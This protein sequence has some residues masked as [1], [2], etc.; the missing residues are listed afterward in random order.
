VKSAGYDPDR[1]WDK[2]EALFAEAKKDMARIQAEDRGAIFDEN[3]EMVG[4][5]D[6]G[7]QVGDPMDL[8]L[9]PID[10]VEEE[11]VEGE[12]GEDEQA[13]EAVPEGEGEGGEEGEENEGGNESLFM[14]GATSP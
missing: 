12:G 8:E 3:G 7:S 11:D 13:E 14:P 5:V 2:E 1:P 10:E 4:E 6:E 9:D